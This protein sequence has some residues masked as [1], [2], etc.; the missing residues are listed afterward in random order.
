ME[1]ADEDDRWDLVIAESDGAHSVWV[2]HYVAAD[3]NEAVDWVQGAFPQIEWT[4]PGA[5][6]VGPP[7]PPD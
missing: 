3:E 6:R 2:R 5:A 4:G 7:R 1:V